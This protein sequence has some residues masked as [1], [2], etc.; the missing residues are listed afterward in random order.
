[1]VINSNLFMKKILVTLATLLYFGASAQ[2]GANEI[3]PAP[4]PTQPYVVLDTLFTLANHPATF[5]DVYVHFANP[6]ATPVKAI[7][8]R[9]FFDDVRFSNVE[10]FWGPTG[11][12]ISTKYGSFFKSGN[13]LNISATYTGTNQNFGWSNGAMFKVR[14][15]HS[16]TYQGV[17]DPVV[18][19]G[20][21]T[22]A[23]LA[24][25]G[26]GVDIPL[27]IHSYGA[28]FQMTPLTFPVYL[29]DVKGMPVS[30]IAVKVSAQLKGSSLPFL[31]APVDTSN[32]T[33]IASYTLPLDT[34]YYKLRVQVQSDTLGDGGALNITD[35][36]AINNAVTQQDTLRAIENFQA[37]INENGAITV[38]DAYAMFNRIALASTTW[39]GFFAGKNNVKLVWQNELNAIKAAPNNYTPAMAPARYTVDTVV[40][41]L[42]S[43]AIYTYVLGDATGTGYNNQAVILAKMASPSAGTDYVLDPIVYFSNKTDS[44][45]FRIPK[46][47][48]STDNFIEVPVTMYTFG[49]KVGAAQ[50]GLRY[51]TAIFEFVSVNVGPEVAKW[52]SIIRSNHGELLWAGHEDP[53]N[54]SLVEG[55]TSAFTFTFKVKSILGWRTSPIVVFDK[56]AG[57]EEANDMNI[58][59]SPNDG[60]VVNGKA[61]MDD[62]TLAMMN[63][64][65]VYP[66]P[67]QDIVVME[68]YTEDFTPLTILVSDVTGRVVRYVQQDVTET[69][70]QLGFVNLYDLD[71]GIYFVRGVT[72]DREKTYK[73]VKQ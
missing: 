13:W 8:F 3:L 54:P 14:L 21:S 56:A 72:N 35:A 39:S 31:T 57:D 26:N 55:P 11:T 20:T 45:E 25:V 43:L 48:L 10:A 29:K 28:G 34:H 46:L 62:K 22:Y 64:F 9:L 19:T 16:A 32:S 37:D 38:S 65:L 15:F 6:T 27:G 53:F 4:N 50:I 12:A 44:V 69:G 58:R 52:T 60:S 1:M 18:T 2:N 63:G 5:T 33:G 17:V 7:Q 30:G 36:Y 42:D 66:N 41:S 51:D 61:E 73:I 24:T 49:N 47:T 59:R 71:R 40:N 68:F 23:N 67:T 70:F